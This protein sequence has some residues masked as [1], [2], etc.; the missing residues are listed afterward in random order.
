MKKKNLYCP[1]CRRKT[2][3]SYAGR[4]SLFEDMGPARAIAAVITFG[5]TETTCAD[6]YWE[7]RICGH[8]KK[9]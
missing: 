3:H 8:I 5:M 1:K 6:K 9:R 4:E 2:L 7:C